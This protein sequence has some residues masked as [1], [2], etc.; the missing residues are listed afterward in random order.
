MLIGFPIPYASIDSGSAF[1]HDP[2]VAAAPNSQ[3]EKQSTK[4]KDCSILI[5]GNH[6]R[7]SISAMMSATDSLR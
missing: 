3:A 2:S 5:H 7:L 6:S 1:R 4:K